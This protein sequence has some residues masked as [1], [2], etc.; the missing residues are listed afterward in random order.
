MSQ[1][2]AQHPTP[3]IARACSIKEAAERLSV[4]QSLLWMMVRSGE[5]RAIKFGRRT[6]IPL[7]EI[8]RVL[9]GGAA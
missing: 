2:S 1:H 6:L 7:S 5:V 3:D 8:M 4:G 9:N